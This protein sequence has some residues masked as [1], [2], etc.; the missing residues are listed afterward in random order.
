MNCSH[1]IVFHYI[2]R[3]SRFGTQKVPVVTICYILDAY[4]GK[5]ARGVSICSPLD[6]FTYVGGRGRAFGRAVTAMKE[7]ASSNPLKGIKGLLSMSTTGVNNYL[8]AYKS[9]WDMQE[10]DCFDS[11]DRKTF[12]RLKKL[13]EKNV[14]V[15]AIGGCSIEMAAPA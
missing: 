10:S 9:K 6:N 11:E 12:L 5:I 14:C 4:T 7:Q 1:E 3:D 8:G 2:F 15:D 13:Y